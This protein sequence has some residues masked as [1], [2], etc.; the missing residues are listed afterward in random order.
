[1]MVPSTTVY[2]F[3]A[4]ISHLHVQLYRFLGNYCLLSLYY[5]GYEQTIK[6]YIVIIVS[7]LIYIFFMYSYNILYYVNHCIFATIYY[8]I[9][10]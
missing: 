9:S 7:L 6:Y 4:E 8:Y 3:Q 10:M 5:C 2:E 1:M